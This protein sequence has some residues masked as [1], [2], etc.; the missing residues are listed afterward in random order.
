MPSL[1]LTAQYW[2]SVTPSNT[3]TIPYDIPPP[4][5]ACPRTVPGL[6]VRRLGQPL[7]GLE[8]AV[9]VAGDAGQGVGRL[10]HPGRADPVPHLPSRPPRVDEPGLLQDGEVLRYRLPAERHVL[11]QAAGRRLAVVDQQVEQPAAGRGGDGRPPAG[12]D[13]PPS[14]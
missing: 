4:L 12:G 11:G 1:S 9:P 7:D 8:P 6:L 13:S 14:P 3:S 10:V 5:S 2:S